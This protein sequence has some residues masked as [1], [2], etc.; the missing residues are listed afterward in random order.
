MNTHNNK[1]QPKS[2]M[3]NHE[4]T[5]K[6]LRKH[7]QQ[8]QSSTAK[9]YIAKAK[10]LLKNEREDSFILHDMFGALNY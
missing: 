3:L 4:Q 8:R 7:G 9:T 5:V 10:A 2:P 6:Q 1:Y